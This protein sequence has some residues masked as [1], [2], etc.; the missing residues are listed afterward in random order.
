MTERLKRSV[1]ERGLYSMALGSIIGVGWVTVLGNWLETAGPIGSALAFLVAGAVMTAVALCYAELTSAL[2]VAGGEIAF[3][4]RAFGAS[5]AFWVGWLLAFGYIAVSA[6]E[7]AAVGRVL[8]YLWPSLPGP[9]LYTV[10]GSDVR[11]G[12]L[13]SGLAFTVL[14]TWLNA[15]GMSLSAGVQ[16]VLTF[17]ILGA[18][19]VFVCGGV[20]RGSV[21]NLLPPFATADPLGAAGG[22]LAVFATAP[23]WFVGFDV[24]PQLA[25]EAHAEVAPARLGK[26]I[27]GSV[28]WATLFYVA[29]ILAASA[30]TPWRDLVGASLPTAAAFEHAFTTHFFADLVLWAALAGLL[31]SWNGFFVAGT[32]VL[33]A[34]GRARLVSPRLAA[35]DRRRGTPRAAV[36]VTGAVT[37]LSCL[38]GEKAMLTFVNV[39]SVC[40]AAA[41]LGVALSASRLRRSAPDLPRPYRMPWGR[42]VAAVA[43][44]GA[45]SICAALVY[46]GSP[47]RLRWPLEWLLFGGWC[48]A[49]AILWRQAAPLRA[50]VA[51]EERARLILTPEG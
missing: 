40:L 28:G 34:L 41:F 38:L 45:L 30:V 15:R 36:L 37:A 5:K 14:F 10:F 43:A 4:Y 27:L 7:A 6:F 13:V 19:V 16:T 11:A 24:I 1:G 18:A 32:R 35:V 31:T 50:S 33:F 3:S 42:A 17:S 26:I 48:A 29:V 22:V 8:A 9:R 12:Y 20:A 51:E 46:P 25:E 23:L 2:P 44:G 21:E 39:S 49:G 47:A